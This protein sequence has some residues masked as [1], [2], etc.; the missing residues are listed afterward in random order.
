MRASRAAGKRGTVPICAKHPPGR[1]G[2]WGLSPFS[3]R[4]RGAFTL[5]ELLVVITIIG[6]LIALLLPAVQAAREAARRLQCAN[7]F[8]QIGVAMHNY[9]SAHGSFPTGEVYSPSPVYLGPA[10]SA[11]LLP[12]MEQTAAYEQYNFSLGSNGV[13][14]EKN[15]L[16]GK[17]RIA[18]YC[19]PADPQD[20]LLCIGHSTNGTSNF[21]D[22]YVYWW[23]TNAGGVTDSLNAW[24]VLVQDPKKYG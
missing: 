5:V 21:P 10:W 23:K 15:E 11:S 2:K 16:V 19:C 1:S 8:R 4:R 7:N 13:Y 9:E 6:I 22:G 18:A 17:Y 14:A 12:Y 24:D 20:E 3:R